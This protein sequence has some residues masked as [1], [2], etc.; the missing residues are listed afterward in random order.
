DQLCRQSINSESLQS[1]TCD[2]VV[3][4]IVKV[5][6][7]ELIRAIDKLGKC[8]HPLSLMLI[9]YTGVDFCQV[10]CLVLPK[11][12]EASQQHA[13]L[14]AIFTISVEWKLRDLFNDL[15]GNFL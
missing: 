5:M 1:G 4:S 2:W 15:N 8:I 12:L 3:R 9:T 14:A 10:G 6:P 11:S 7:A 13:C